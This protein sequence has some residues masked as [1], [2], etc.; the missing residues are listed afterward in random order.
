VE[1]RPAIPPVAVTCGR[2]PADGC[3]PNR[4]AHP[5]GSAVRTTSL[6]TPRPT[7]RS[8]C[9]ADGPTVRMTPRTI[10]GYQKARRT[11]PDGPTVRTAP[12][13]GPAHREFLPA[14]PPRCG[15]ELPVHRPGG[16]LHAWAFSLRG[17]R[18]ALAWRTP[19]L[20]YR[21]PGVP[22]AFAPVPLRA[23]ESDHRTNA[24]PG[25]SATGHATGSTLWGTQRPSS[26]ARR[27]LSSPACQRG[28]AAGSP[29]VTPRGR[30]VSSEQS[31]VC[32]PPVFP[33]VDPAPCSTASSVAA[34]RGTG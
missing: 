33:G 27:P 19:R 23:R 32:R 25:D 31:C 10:S 20:T 6:A 21:S 34:D 2:R 22:L 7:G 29:Q 26:P 15:K 17:M 1:P 14:P 13:H 11:Q 5:D 24:L 4:P 3:P 18:D 8:P 30:R 16:D 28:S 12:W 9:S